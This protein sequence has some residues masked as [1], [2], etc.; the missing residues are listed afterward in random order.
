VPLVDVMDSTWLRARPQAVGL[1]VADPPLWQRW[2]PGLELVA[3]EQRADKG[4]RWDVRSVEGFPG[5]TGTAELWLQA[6]GEGV[7]AHFFLRLD[8]AGDIDDAAGNTVSGRDVEALRWRYRLSTKRALWALGDQLD[9]G[10][11]E[12]HTSA[13]PAP[14][15]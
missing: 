6:Q 9:P 11:L 2:W 1:I 3:Y 12:R 13:R 7:V 10:R 4:I 8:V 5:L 15:A 14:R